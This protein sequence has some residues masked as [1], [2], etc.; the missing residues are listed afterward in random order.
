MGMAIACQTCPTTAPSCTAELR[1]SG[2]GLRCSELTGC[3]DWG[4]CGND[5]AGALATA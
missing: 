5:K 4:V 1:D 2:T 3:C